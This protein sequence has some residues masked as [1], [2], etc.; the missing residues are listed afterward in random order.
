MDPTIESKVV[1]KLIKERETMANRKLTADRYL[2]AG[3]CASPLVDVKA[4]M[5]PYLAFE[6]SIINRMNLDGA[7]LQSDW[8][9]NVCLIVSIDPWCNEYVGENAANMFFDFQRWQEG[10]ESLLL[11]WSKDALSV[12]SGAG[13]DCARRTSVAL[14]LGGE[15]RG[16]RLTGWTLTE[17]RRLTSSTTKI[18]HLEE[19]ESNRDVSL[20]ESDVVKHSGCPRVSIFVA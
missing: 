3:F 6:F 11:G 7:G 15:V 10:R 2:S 19:V 12:A 17:L 14:L 9:V 20:L 5:S 18:S 1:M 16:K 4:G 8:L 13:A